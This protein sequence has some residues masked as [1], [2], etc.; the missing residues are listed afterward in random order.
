MSTATSTPKMSID[1]HSASTEP[2]TAVGTGVSEPAVSSSSRADV[3]ASSVENPYVA[4][5]T[6]LASLQDATY[7]VDLE[8]TVQDMAGIINNMEAQ[9]D[10]VLS[11]NAVFEEDLTTSKQLISELRTEKAK[12]VEELSKLKE[13]I[14]SKREMQMEMDQLIEERSASQNKIHSLK[15]EIES[16]NT[17]IEVYRKQLVQIEMER[18]DAVSEVSFHES[19]QAATRQKNTHQEQKINQIK[20]EKVTFQKKIIQ[21]QDECQRAMEEK[22]SLLRELQEAQDIL[23]E[24]SRH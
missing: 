7:S 1:P 8:K 22:Y 15:L 9:L 24:V 16:M 17:Q 3:H 2:T 5:I 20:A 21:L 14:P 6:G 18:N 4:E 10:R 19:R 13:D 12:L 23:S 11:M